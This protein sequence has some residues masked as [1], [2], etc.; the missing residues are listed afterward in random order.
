MDQLTVVQYLEENKDFLFPNKKY[1]EL[2]VERELMAA[3]DGF[4]VAMRSIP[5]R[6][7]STLKLIAIFPGILGVDRFYMGEIVRGILKY[8]SFG[9]VGIWWIADIISAKERCRAYNCKK[10]MEAVNNPLII[11]QMQAF[12]Q[13]VNRGVDNAKKWAPVLGAAVKGAKDIRDTF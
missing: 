8:F 3:P 11:A 12:D 1:N 2:D 13:K 6:K 9:G 10:L 5:F 7:P 4:E